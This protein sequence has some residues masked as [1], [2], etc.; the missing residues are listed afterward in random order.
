VNISDAEFWF[1]KDCAIL[2]VVF[3][4]PRSYTAILKAVQDCSR[5][6][7]KRRRHVGNAGTRPKRCLDY[8]MADQLLLERDG[9]TASGVGA[10]L[11]AFRSKA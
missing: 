6:G 4:A 9:F 5:V 3:A 1:R 11:T 8:N 2:G 7:R 10:S